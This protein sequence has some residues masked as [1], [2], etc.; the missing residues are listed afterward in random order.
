MTPLTIA[1][2][3][4]FGGSAV[5]GGAVIAYNKSQQEQQDIDKVIKSLETQFEKAQASAV[6]NLD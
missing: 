6:V 4:F 2:I 1:L 5:T 3:A